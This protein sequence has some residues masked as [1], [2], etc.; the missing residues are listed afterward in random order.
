MPRIDL[1]V[2]AAPENDRT[3]IVVLE[4][5]QA[6]EFVADWRESDLNRHDLLLGVVRRQVPHL[7][8]VF[9]DIGQDHD[10]LLRLAAAEPVP[11]VGSR[12]MVTLTRD[13][14]PALL[15]KGPVLSTGMALAG[16]YAVYR[17]DLKPLRRSLLRELPPAEADKLFE[18][19]LS[20]LEKSYKLLLK[21]AENGTAPRRLRAFG[22]PLLVRLQAFATRLDSIKV[23]GVDAYT[24]VEQLLLAEAPDLLP[25]LRLHPPHLEQGLAELCSLPDLAKEAVKRIVPLPCGGTLTFD[26]TEALHVIDVNSGSCREASPAALATRVNREAVAEI[27]RQ[28]RL[29]NLNGMVII[30]L[31]HLKDKTKQVEFAEQ[32]QRAADSDRGKVTVYGFT[33]LQLLEVIRKAH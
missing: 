12:I 4:D 30:D 14:E 5:R 24:R 6:V 9:V 15:A 28:L 7:G 25:L 23:E 1:L 20:E 13:S 8:G 19:E 26:R 18:Y 29:R 22:D 3:G 11:A 33:A 21:A 32:L 16:R 2:I 10:G 27:A 31:I 17:P